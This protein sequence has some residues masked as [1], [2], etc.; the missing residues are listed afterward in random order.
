[1]IKDNKDQNVYLGQMKEVFLE[2]SVQIFFPL[3]HTCILDNVISIKIII[4][5]FSDTVPWR[6]A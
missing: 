3:K 4:T 1:M 6:K 2:V 5:T